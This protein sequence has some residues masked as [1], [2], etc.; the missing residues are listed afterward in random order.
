MEN[1]ADT[2][3]EKTIELYKYVYSTIDNAWE[4]CNIIT[5]LLTQLEQ[6]C[7]KDPIELKAKDKKKLIND[8]IFCEAH[9]ECIVIGLFELEAELYNNIYDT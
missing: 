4:I 2:I 3:L 9:I 5:I 6:D 7:D 1:E 8:L